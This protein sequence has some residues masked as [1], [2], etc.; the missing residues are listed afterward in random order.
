MF[1]RPMLLDNLKAGGQEEGFD[2]APG[3]SPSPQ[4]KGRKKTSYALIVICISYLLGIGILRV[5][6]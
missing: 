4:Y 5:E 1:W 2:K 6:S 3:V